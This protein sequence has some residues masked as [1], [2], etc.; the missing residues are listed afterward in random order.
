MT[1]QDEVISNLLNAAYEALNQLAIARPTV[2]RERLDGQGHSPFECNE[3][4]KEIILSAIKQAEEA[5]PH[6]AA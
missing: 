4:G 5:F 2:S 3:I 6:L 1:R